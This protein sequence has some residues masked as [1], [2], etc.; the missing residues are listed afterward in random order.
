MNDTGKYI[1]G[2]K[3][4]L[5]IYFTADYPEKGDTI[6]IIRSLQDASADLIE[7][8]IPFSDPL[9][10]GPV[11]QTSSHRAIRNGFNLTGL[12]GDISTIRS[13]IKIPLVLM[14]YL[15]NALVF[16][17]ERFLVNCNE[18]GIDTVILPDMPLDIYKKKYIRT[19]EKY[20]VAP[21][22]LISPQTN[23]ERIKEIDGLSKSFIY[24]VADN[25]VTG[26]TGGVRGGQ[27]DYF[28]RIRNLELNSPVLI[29]FGISDNKSYRTACEYSN[30][31]IIGSAFIRAITDCNDLDASI[32]NFISSIKKRKNDY[33]TSP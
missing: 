1:A 12:F 6:K 21:A 28:E 19:F 3:D 2:K 26:R 30:G 7:V 17:I 20:D 5:S 25:T 32:R 33:S 15:N 29:G 18:S 10:D 9:A 11:I 8:G 23:N 22:F 4:L 14:G 31:A 24:A 27:Y 16:G 13:E